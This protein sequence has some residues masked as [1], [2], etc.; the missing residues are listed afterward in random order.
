MREE[1]LVY[2]KTLQFTVDSV[3]GVLP[4]RLRHYSLVLLGVTTDTGLCSYPVFKYQAAVMPYEATQ[5]QCCQTHFKFTE[6]WILNKVW[7]SHVQKPF[8]IVN[9]AVCLFVF[10]WI[11]CTAVL[12]VCMF[13][14]YIRESMEAR[15]RQLPGTRR[16][17]CEPHCGCWELNLG[18]LGEPPVL[19]TVE[20][21]L[22]PLLQKFS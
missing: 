17:G 2:N 1:R 6:C 3:A 19:L 22:Q 20:P 21:S 9:L 15:G 14:Y 7:W 5:A 8:M 16:D 10:V 11:M 18:S 13:S 4:R 12:L